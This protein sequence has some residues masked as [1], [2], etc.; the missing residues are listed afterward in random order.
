MNSQGTH[1]LVLTLYV[2]WTKDCNVIY[3]QLTSYLEW[4]CCILV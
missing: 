1:V 3:K 2:P 4:T